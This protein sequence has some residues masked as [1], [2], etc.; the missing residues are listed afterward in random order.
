MASMRGTSTGDHVEAEVR[1][2]LMRIGGF[3]QLKCLVKIRLGRSTSFIRK[4]SKFDIT[5]T[6]SSYPPPLYIHVHSARCYPFRYR[7][8]SFENLVERR[9]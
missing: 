6:T 8:S 7:D 4:T 5:A 2:D 1:T 9:R 3:V